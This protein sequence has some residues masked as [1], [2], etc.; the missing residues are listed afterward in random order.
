MGFL[1]SIINIKLCGT[2]II[3]RVL[4][5]NTDATRDIDR[6]IFLS[7]HAS[8]CRLILAHVLMLNELHTSLPL[9]ILVSFL[10]NSETVLHIHICQHNSYESEL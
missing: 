9:I 4:Y 2:G 1:K 7:N 6:S 5:G 10:C 3:F 8:S